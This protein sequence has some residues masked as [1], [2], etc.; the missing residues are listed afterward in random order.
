M[1]DAHTPAP[2]DGDDPA[3]ARLRAADPAAGA[4]PDL[5]RVRSALAGVTGSA[6]AGAG[7]ATDATGATQA[8]TAAT[9]ATAAAAAEPVGAAQAAA[10]HGDDAP[11]VEEITVD[12]LAAARARRRPAR[13]LQVAAAVAGI[14]AIGSAGYLVGTARADTTQTAGTAEPAI[15]PAGPVGA[16][17]GAQD[18]AAVGSAPFAATDKA[19]AWY[20]GRTV[21][22]SRGLSDEGASGKAWALDAA[23]VYSA[24]TVGHLA[25]VLQVP[26]EPVQQYGTWIVGPQDGSGPSVSLA[27]D[28]AA[29][30]TYYDPTRDPWSCV[31]SAPDEI[32]KLDPEQGDGNE[33]SAG[34]AVAPVAP[35]VDVPSPCAAGTASAPGADDAK[36][37]AR[38]LLSA[39]GLDPAGYE[40]EVVDPGTSQAAS[41]SAYQVVD[42]A[43][44]GMTWSFTVLADG[45]QSMWGSLAPLVD[46]GSYDVVSP[47]EAVERLGDARFGFSS[48]GVMPLAMTARGAAEGAMSDMMPAPETTPTVPA[49]PTAGARLGWPVQEVEITSARLGVAPATLPG[50]ASVL[51]PTYELS[52]ADGS[53]WSVIAV[54]DD[55]LDFSPAG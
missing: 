37:Q 34:S 22:S 19:S 24:A 40:L 53:T 55:R 11:V 32:Q 9:A 29:S 4:E 2:S 30:V 36:A 38:D 8:A 23:S 7:G 49:T 31:R 52:S 20:G 54:V 35:P 33:G 44:T 25:E 18:S 47:A 45:V 13:W 1:N 16:P 51:V 21:F 12:E 27:A 26:G 3:F 41:V 39:L 14:A 46:L 15:A 43:R 5:A 42:G 10:A 28:G 50:G 17:E 48:G 6:A